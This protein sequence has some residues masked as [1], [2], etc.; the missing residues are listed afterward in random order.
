MIALEYV[1]RILVNTLNFYH[2]MRSNLETI[3]SLCSSIAY[4]AVDNIRR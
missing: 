3:N 4:E 1:E 2:M